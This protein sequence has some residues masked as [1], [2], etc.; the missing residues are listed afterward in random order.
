MSDN[1]NLRASN[2]A[3]LSGRQ[4]LDS[5]IRTNVTVNPSVFGGGLL[6]PINVL[7]I[8]PIIPQPTGATATNTDVTTERSASAQFTQLRVKPGDLITADLINTIL[9]ALD[10]LDG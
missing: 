4:I 5:L 8:I 9:V 7:P 3:S 10:Y 2:L 6:Q 1:P